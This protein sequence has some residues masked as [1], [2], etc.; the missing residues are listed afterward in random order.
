MVARERVVHHL[1]N[2]RRFL[3]DL[4]RYQGV[5][6]E[7]FLGDR[8]KQNM[9]LFVLLEAIQHCIDL[10][11]HIISEMGWGR[12]QTYRDVF[13]VLWENQLIGDSLRDQLGDLAGFRNV[14]M[15]M[16]GKLDLDKVYERLQSDPGGIREF[17]KIVERLLRKETG[18]DKAALGASP[19]L[20]AP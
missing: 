1:D 3:Q 12:A 7:E 5:S 17:A 10:G 15:H 19:P 4:A 18:D 16:Y 6:R 2:L 11:N 8:D 14:I 13:R 9:V 20:D